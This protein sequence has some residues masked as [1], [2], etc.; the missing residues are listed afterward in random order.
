MPDDAEVATLIA[1]NSAWEAQ[2]GLVLLTTR[3]VR[4][5]DW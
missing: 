2:L 4:S 1:L 5:L 3:Q